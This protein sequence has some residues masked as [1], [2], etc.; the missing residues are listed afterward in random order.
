MVASASRAAGMP[1]ESQTHVPHHRP[2]SDV[3]SKVVGRAQK[4]LAIQM[5]TV[6]GV[7]TRAWL[8]PSRRNERSVS[9]RE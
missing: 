6:P 5:S 9:S 7:K 2:R 4:G 3:T 1:N 8:S